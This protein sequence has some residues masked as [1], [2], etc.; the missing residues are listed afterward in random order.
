MQYMSE[1]TALRVLHVIT[2]DNPDDTCSWV[3]REFR[4]FTVD[5]ICHNPTMKLEYLAV[6]QAL[7]RLV[8]RKPMLK[9]KVDKKG[10]GKEMNWTSAKALAELVMGSAAVATTG[11]WSEDGK[12]D[13]PDSSDDED[14]IVKTGLRVETIDGIRFSDVTGVRIFERDVLIG[15]L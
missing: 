3:F 1:L 6:E 12:Y 13:F 4:K 14:G 15:R 7:D 5:V 2:F 11:G 9:P 8:R 10:K